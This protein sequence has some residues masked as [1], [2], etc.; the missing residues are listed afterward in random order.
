MSLYRF[1]YRN[2][3]IGGWSAFVGWLI[4]EILFQSESGGL[5]NVATVCAAVGAFLGAGLS[6]VGGMS[7]GQ[8]RQQLKRALPG[9]AIGALGG[10]LGGFFGDLFYK[11]GLP[12]A[13]GWLILGAVVG[14]GQGLYERSRTKLRNGLIG[15]AAGGFA[16]GLLFDWIQA[17]IG[18]NADMT[19]RA[20]A[21][22][23]LGACI[24][25]C[26]GVVQVAL[27]QAWLTVVD[28]W[29]PNRQLI[30]NEGVTILGRAE[31]ASLP[32]LGESNRGL[33]LEHVKI[34]R[35]SNGR[36]VAEPSPSAS[37][38]VID[39]QP[40]FGRVELKDDD[41]IKIGGNYIRFNER[42]Q[43][44][45]A[46]S[47]PRPARQPKPQ[48]PP[49]LKPQT[50][51]PIQTPPP[52]ISQPSPPPLKPETPPQPKL[53]PK[54]VAPPPP[55]PTPAV[56]PAAPITPP[57]PT[58]PAAATQPYKPTSPPP[59]VAK[60]A[61]SPPPPPSPAR[62]PEP[63]KGAFCRNGHPIPSPG[64]FCIICDE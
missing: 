34:R 42:A 15:G 53:E 32:F 44:S 7:N 22:V 6:F 52:Q 40:A 62:T 21:F 2:S 51:Q 26:V 64:S 25:A 63:A 31:Y 27:K 17:V 14:A 8:W 57:R 29:R 56:A 43:K 20:T 3:V 36:Y 10:F 35:E 47:S 1:I 58:A 37:D 13:L 39:R 19:S 30:L 41:V 46:S 11:F 5:L 9:F 55:P 61:A 24:G 23:L 50:P 49:P 28:G 33:E 60:P 45:A 48:A 54:P 12:R 59:P 16:G 38:V 18:Q 4:S